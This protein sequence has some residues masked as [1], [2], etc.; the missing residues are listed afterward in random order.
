MQTPTTPPPPKQP[1]IA[2]DLKADGCAAHYAASLAC[3]ESAARKGLDKEACQEA[4]DAYKACRATE[5]RMRGRERG[6]MDGWK[7]SVFF[8]P[9]FVFLTRKHTQNP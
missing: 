5:V 1:H 6:W 8:P 7:T 9:F 2:T 3:L 4:F